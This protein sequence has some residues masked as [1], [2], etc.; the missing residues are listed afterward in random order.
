MSLGALIVNR[1][2]GGEK[3]FPARKWVMV[4]FATFMIL[5]IIAGFG[6]VARLETGI[7]PW[8]FAKLVLW[9]LVGSFMSV[10]LRKPEWSKLNWF[11]LLLL[12]ATGA[13]VALYKPF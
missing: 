10:I 5:A 6:A 2:N 12:G 9:L 8:V 13:Y 4:S 1:M 11:V 3:D 7:E